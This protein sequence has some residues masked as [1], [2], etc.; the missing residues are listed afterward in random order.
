VH[1]KIIS[2]FRNLLPSWDKLIDASFLEKNKKT[3]FKQLIR[4]KIERLG[5]VKA[6]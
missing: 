2:N 4:K 1:E 5:Q 6:K 3:Q